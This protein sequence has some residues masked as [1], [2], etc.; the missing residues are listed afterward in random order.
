MS[1]PTKDR[2][3]RDQI[4]FVQF[5]RGAKL[6][7]IIS[8]DRRSSSVLEA[9]SLRIWKAASG[10]WSLP[11]WREV[12]EIIGVATETEQKLYGYPAPDPEAGK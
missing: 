4:V 11:T 12:D 9:Y 3:F 8:R 6:A 1:E 5:K 2:Y 10:R 7:Q